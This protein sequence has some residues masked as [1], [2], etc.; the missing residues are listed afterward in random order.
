MIMKPV[1]M[2]LQIHQDGSVS[3]T[4]IGSEADSGA[5]SGR[6]GGYPQPVTPAD[7][8]NYSFHGFPANHWVETEA[9]GDGKFSAAVSSGNAWWV[10]E[11]NG[12]VTVNGSMDYSPVK[13]GDKNRWCI[14]TPDY[15]DDCTYTVSLP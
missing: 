13:K 7:G 4:V 9:G 10:V 8:R 6:E 3:G 15:Q 1:S 14:T 12:V 5:V 11:V 2:N